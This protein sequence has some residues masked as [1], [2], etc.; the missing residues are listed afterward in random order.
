MKKVY[1]VIAILSIVI[2]GSG[3]GPSQE[4]IRLQKDKIEKVRLLEL[5]KQKKYKI[6]KYKEAEEYIKKENDNVLIWQ[7][8][9]EN[10]GK[11]KKSSYETK[12]EYDA[13]IKKLDKQLFSKKFLF[14]YKEKYI[15]YNP[16]DKILYLPVSTEPQVGS[17]YINR[18]ASWNRVALLSVEV[19]YMALGYKLSRKY[20][21]LANIKHSNS[22]VR[23]FYQ[24]P[25]YKKGMRYIGLTI[26][27]NCSSIEAK[28]MQDNWSVRFVTKVVGLDKVA[29]KK[30]KS[31]IIKYDILKTDMTIVYNKKTNEIY[32]VF[33]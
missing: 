30:K 19:P 13:R 4:E 17:Y 29:M 25:R 15:G 9:E 7:T 18:V 22:A 27:E 6:K 23:A 20:T 32:K 21:L 10:I 2:L 1:A 3:C 16:E 31:N 11:Y 33:Y 26:K 5:E 24:N 8:L 14:D 12:V 28:Y